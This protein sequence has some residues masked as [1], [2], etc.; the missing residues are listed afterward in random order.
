MEPIPSEPFLV[1]GAT[2][3][4]ASFLIKLLLEKGYKV[5]GT[6]RS[7]SNKSSY[8]FLYDMVPEKK[9]NLEFIEADLTDKA[10]WEK[11]TKGVQYVFH[12]ASPVTAADAP[13]TEE[14]Y[15]KPAIEG[16][17]NVLEASLA[18]GVKKVVVTSTGATVSLEKGTR[19]FTEEDWQAEND[20][21]SFYGKSK[22]RA[23]KA[24][25]DF[26]EKNKGK[27]EMTVVNPCLTFGPIL[28]IRGNTS[29]FIGHIMNGIWPG[30][31]D[32]L[33][34]V[35]DVRDVAEVHVQA[36]FR[37]KANGQRYICAGESVT[38]GNIADWL[39]KAFGDKGIRV[40]DQK[41][42]LEDFMNSENPLVKT[43]G[44]FFRHG[45]EFDHSKSEKDLEVKYLPAEK[46]IVDT[47]SDLLKFGIVKGNNN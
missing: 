21:M 5:I 45:I 30:V 9:D 36:M 42:T 29:S 26:Y 4:I 25:W 3:Y 22:I 14:F 8:E 39:N 2:G 16:T 6:I 7:L 37:E 11:A 13:K 19:P 24:A 20:S 32:T 15:I 10:S 44:F 40:P 28:T 46:T 33:L 43:M 31:F 47:G 27:I 18:N 17:L 38:L 12:V 34:P 1:T 35:V 23:E 41:V